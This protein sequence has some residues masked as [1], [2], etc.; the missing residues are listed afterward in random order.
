[1]RRGRPRCQRE[2]WSRVCNWGSVASVRYL[3]I[4]LL[5]FLTVTGADAAVIRVKPLGV[6][7]VLVLVKGDLELS[8]IDEFRS[9]VS[10]VPK[11]TVAFESDGGSLIAGIRI[12]T[13]IRLKNLVTVVPDG[14][15]CASACA[16]AWLGGSRRYVGAGAKVGFHS[17]YIL[18][19]G[20]AAESGPGNA[21]LGAYLNQLGLPEEAIVYITQAAPNSMIWLNTRDAAQHGIDVS[22][23]PH[24]GVQQTVNLEETLV[25]ERPQ[26]A[27]QRRAAD[28]VDALAA[29]WSEPNARALDALGD[30][31]AD[32][33]VYYGKATSRQWILYDK[34]HFAERWP[35]RRYRIRAGSMSTTCVDRT[36]MC[37]VKGTLDWEFANGTVP[38]AASASHGVATFDYSI[39]FSASTPKITAESSSFNWRQKP[40]PPPN[41]LVAV[42]QSLQNLVAQIVQLRPFQK[43]SPKSHHAHQSPSQQ[44]RR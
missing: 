17:A 30:L 38:T 2:T 31:Y 21:V 33:V 42:Q 6:G 28:F 36:Q 16:I 15:Q 4:V 19:G 13:L 43:T 37:R 3:L 44:A 8:D 25:E 9:R 27:L 41:S 22:L 29:R 23:L 34:R 7:E 24:S 35:Q 20:R 11:A 12:G 39:D 26:N 5:S 10:A 40:P 14:A 1:M 32:P 18:E